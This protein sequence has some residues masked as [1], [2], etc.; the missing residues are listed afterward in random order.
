[1]FIE[2]KI[3]FAN[4]VVLVK[5]PV[6]SKHLPYALFT[7]LEFLLKTGLT[8]VCKSNGIFTVDS[9]YLDFGYLE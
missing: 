1:M 6:I 4:A 5:W 7:F 3:S 8:V 9:R 2:A